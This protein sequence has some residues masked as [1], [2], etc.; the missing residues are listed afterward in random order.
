MSDRV[1][2]TK[3]QALRLAKAVSDCSFLLETFLRHE[4]WSDG[5]TKK[6]INSELAMDR[7]LSALH[8]ILTDKLK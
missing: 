6:Q 1:Y 5:K 4:D 7:E 8:K 2:L 3:V